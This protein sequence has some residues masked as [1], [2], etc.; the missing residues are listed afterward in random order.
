MKDKVLIIKTDQD[1]LDKV[2]YL[3]RI[4]GY[5]SKSDTIRKTVEK[6]YRKETDFDCQF[7]DTCEYNNVCKGVR[8]LRYGINLESLL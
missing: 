5:K 1:L 4:N 3:Q 6:E 2:E 8:C 7:K